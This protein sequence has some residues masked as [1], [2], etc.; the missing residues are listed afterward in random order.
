VILKVLIMTEIKK[1]AFFAFLY[2]VG[3]SL[4]LKVRSLRATPTSKDAPRSGEHFF[5][6][7][8]ASTLSVM[9]KNQKN[10]QGWGRTIDLVVYLRNFG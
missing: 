4:S 2:F 7:H 1:F 6:S 5:G 8:T 3:E 10:A 9:P